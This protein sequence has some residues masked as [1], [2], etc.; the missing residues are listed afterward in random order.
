MNACD[1]VNHCLFHQADPEATTVCYMCRGKVVWSHDVDNGY[2]GFW[3][4]PEHGRLNTSD[5]VLISYY[6]PECPYSR[7]HRG[8]SKSPPRL[9]LKTWTL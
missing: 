1:M 5:E 2:I 4:C 7:L 9:V 3:L 8:K 6:K